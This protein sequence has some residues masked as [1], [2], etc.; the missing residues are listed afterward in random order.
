MS[1]LFQNDLYGSSERVEYDWQNDWT[2][3]DGLMDHIRECIKVVAGEIFSYLY[4]AHF[5]SFS[6]FFSRLLAIPRGIDTHTQ[7]TQC[8]L[9]MNKVDGYFK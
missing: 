8:L 5:I 9:N 2:L 1:T 6:L 7:K 3:P 4:H